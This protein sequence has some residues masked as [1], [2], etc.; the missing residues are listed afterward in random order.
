MEAFEKELHESKAKDVEEDEAPEAQQEEVDEAELGDDP[1][2]GTGGAVGLDAGN[3]P[4][5][6]SD[7]DYAYPEVRSLPFNILAAR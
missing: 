6:K 7:R 5:L 1:F 3:E 4:W 2:A